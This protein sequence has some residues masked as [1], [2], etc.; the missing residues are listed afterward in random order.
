MTESGRGTIVRAWP[1]VISLVLSACGSAA[2]PQPRFDFND[3]V[4]AAS[5]AGTAD[6]R[7]V[8]GGVFIEDSDK[9]S[10]EDRFIVGKPG[11]VLSG[12]RITLRVSNIQTSAA[13]LRVWYEDSNHKINYEVAFDGKGT[14]TVG[15]LGPNE[16]GGLTP[17]EV[18]SSV[19]DGKVTIFLSFPPSPLSN[20]IAKVWL[21]PAVGP[22]TRPYDPAAVGSLVIES[23]SVS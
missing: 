17:S 4:S 18:K 9:N 5:W 20:G 6:V 14:F 21:Y 7:I 16:T 2:P 11:E 22:L 3:D 23:I 1:V 13:V 10:F 8:Q 12:T 15:G 19:S